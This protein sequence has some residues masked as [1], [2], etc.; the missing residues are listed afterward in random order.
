MDFDWS[1]DVVTIRQL[2]KLTKFE[3]W[4]TSKYVAIEDPFNLEHNLGQA[5]S[6]RSDE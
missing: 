6:S 2:D 1:T 4:W 3:K 5:V